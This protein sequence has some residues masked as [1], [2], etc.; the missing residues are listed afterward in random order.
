MYKVTWSK[1][2]RAF[3]VNEWAFKN[4]APQTH[5]KEYDTLNAIYRDV[6]VAWSKGY[7]PRVIESGEYAIR[8]NGIRNEP[9]Y[10]GSVFQGLKYHIDD[11]KSDGGL[12]QHVIKLRESQKRAEEFWATLG[13]RKVRPNA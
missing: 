6:E 11:I 13:S 5:I 9:R 7:V 12:A 1:K 8:L 2:F 3:G 10:I 4:N